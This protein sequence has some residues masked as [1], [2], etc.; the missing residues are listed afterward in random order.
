MA[1]TRGFKA[2]PTSAEAAAPK[3]EEGEK[4]MRRRRDAETLGRSLSGA[5]GK[6][7]TGGVSVQDVLA[8]ETGDEFDKMFERLKRE[9]GG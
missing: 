3:P 6:P 4:E 5:G 7:T 2:K 9:S 1:R 8:A